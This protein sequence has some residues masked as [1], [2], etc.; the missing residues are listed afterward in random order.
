MVTEVQSS[1]LTDQ[2]Y[3]KIRDAILS[4][5]FPVGYRLRV[6]DLA[7]LVGTSVMPVREAIRRLEEAGLAEREPHKGAV[8]KEL[9]LSEL[10]HVYD[11]RRLLE[12]EGARLG[13]E[14]ISAADVDRMTTEYEAMRE[15]IIAEDVPEYLDRDEALLAILYE[16]SGNPVLLQTIRSLWSRCRA[17]KLVGAQG[18]LGS[19]RGAQL[20]TYQRELIDAAAGNDS[21]AAAAINDRSLVDATERI[22]EL[23]AAQTA[24]D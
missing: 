3:E 6:R 22:E 12:V 17:Y 18:T 2:V 19:E 20:W 7:T 1:L 11:V 4:G 8:V 13:A 23:L 14:R 9:S 24:G 21:A 5:E 16:A 10:K 15:A